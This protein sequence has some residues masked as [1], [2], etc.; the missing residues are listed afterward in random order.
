MSSLQYVSNIFFLCSKT[1]LRLTG[2]MDDPDKPRNAC[3]IKAPAGAL[4]C[5]AA[6]TLSWLMVSGSEE[7]VS[8]VVRIKVQDGDTFRFPV[9]VA[10]PFCMRHHSS[11]RE[12][13]VKIVDEQKRVSF[14]TP[15]ITDEVHR[16]RKVLFSVKPTS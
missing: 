2:Q 1:I 12:V 9:T 3:Y 13:A 4:K 14:I 6:D 7:L 8:R 10:M 5:D 15:V 16:G 11:H